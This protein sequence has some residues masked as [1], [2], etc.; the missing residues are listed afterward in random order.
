MYAKEKD[1]ELSD[2]DSDD[3]NAVFELEVSPLFQL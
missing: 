1:D 2:D 3:E